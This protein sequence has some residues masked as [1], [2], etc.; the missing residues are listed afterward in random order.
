MDVTELCKTLLNT[1]QL[2]L[3]EIE[4][5]EGQ[6]GLLVEGTQGQ[7][8]CPRC[9]QISEK[10]HSH[11]KRYPRDLAWAQQ[12]VVLSIQTKRFYCLNQ[13]CPKRTFAES[14]SGYVEKYARRTNRVIEKQQRQGIS[15]S[16]RTAE[17]LL[18]SEQIKISDTTINRQIRSLPEPEVE[19]VE[20]L[21]VDDWAKRKGQRY[22][23]LLVDQ[24]N[25]RVVDVLEDRTAE[26]LET[27]LKSH[28]EIK[29]VTR[30]RS[31]TYAEGIRNGAPQAIQVAD[32]WH[33]MK[34][35]SE[36][37]YKIF[38][39][40]QTGIEKRLKEKPVEEEALEVP[41]SAPAVIQKEMT[42]AK[43][44]QKQRME[45]ALGLIGLGWTQKAAANQLNI[46]P[47]T[48]RRY[49]NSPAPRTRRLRANGKLDPYKPF[50]LQRWNEGCHNAAQLFREIQPQ[51]YT[52]QVTL[53]MNYTRQ[54]RLA[55]GLPPRVRKGDSAILTPEK[56]R[57]LPSMRTLTWWVSRPIEKR[58]EE[59]EQMLRKAVGSEVKIQ[60]T[61]GLARDFAQMIRGRQAD[62]LSSWIDRAKE[63]G[64]PL[65][66]N[67][68]LSLEQDQAAVM[69]ALTY[70]WSN[71]RTEGNVNRLKTLKRM[72]YG[73]A[74]DDLLRKRVI[75]Y[76]HAFT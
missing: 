54:L 17:T 64:N 29:I 8:N 56:I 68:A 55:G 23:T 39:Q 9:K 20:V 11:Y 32:R 2:R 6:I 45:E 65:W 27:W 26:T 42:Q 61:L 31:K 38:Q 41:K 67:F 70:S 34:N 71:G 4:I 58:R 5:E 35:V 16:A 47:K 3:C 57:D 30:D 48:V 12:P 59:N 72:M 52:G 36:V 40:E 1:D 10:V 50:L 46:H 69:A 14:F 22:G 19:K 18:A 43:K 15:T 21:G 13:A 66:L 62:S 51:G 7:A 33:L 53:L 25:K 44:R 37:V 73:R 28:P 75:S 76:L 74:K 60:T 24:E 49:L 63:S